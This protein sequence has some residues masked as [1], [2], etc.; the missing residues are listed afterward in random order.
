MLSPEF[1]ATE[2]SRP[3]KR[4]GHDAG[5]AAFAGGSQA[6]PE[7]V[8]K[9][10]KLENIGFMDRADDGSPT[11]AD[12][13]D[14]IDAVPQGDPSASA[15]GEPL[16]KAQAMAKIVQANQAMRKEDAHLKKRNVFLYQHRRSSCGAAAALFPFPPSRV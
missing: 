15:L 6:M 16:S 10:P 3:A 5:S 11:L 7:H 9:R 1:E 12:D 13:D 2:A 8:L 14:R 4:P